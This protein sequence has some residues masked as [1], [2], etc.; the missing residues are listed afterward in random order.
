MMQIEKYFGHCTFPTQLKQDHK[1]MFYL[2]NTVRVLDK[3]SYINILEKK[4]SV[5]K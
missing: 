1:L 5:S 2:I 4:K 3:N